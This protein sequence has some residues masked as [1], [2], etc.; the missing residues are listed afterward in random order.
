MPWARPYKQWWRSIRDNKPAL[1]TVLLQ[2]HERTTRALRSP[3]CA[4]LALTSVL[5]ST[6]SLHVAAS[7]EQLFPWARTHRKLWRSIPDNKPAL[8]PMLFQVHERTACAPGSPGCAF[9]TVLLSTSSHMWRLSGSRVCRAP[10]HTASC[11]EVSLLADTEG[12]C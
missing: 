1:A 3:G 10:G 6:S 5:L 8:A 2:V 7:P 9:I 12:R 11:G 4:L